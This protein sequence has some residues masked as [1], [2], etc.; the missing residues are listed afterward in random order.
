ME[1][2]RDFL[3]KDL[4][5]CIGQ[6]IDYYGCG[7]ENLEI[8]LIQEAKTGIFGIVGAR[9]A[10][11]R[12]RRAHV[13]EKVASMLNAT[14][15]MELGKGGRKP[16][17]R[18]ERQEAGPGG[19]GGGQ[20][21]TEQGKTSATRQ[22]RQGAPRAAGALSPDKGEGTDRPDRGER[23]EL[24]RAAREDRGRRQPGGEKSGARASADKAV[25]QAPKE[26]VNP[27]E[28][29]RKRGFAP[30]EAVSR[31]DVSAGKGEALVGGDASVEE[32]HGDDLENSSWPAR[33]LSELDEGVL[34][35]QT[36]EIVGRILE[37]IAGCPLQMTMELAQRSVRIHV[38][39]AGDAGLLIGRDGQTLAAVQYI[40]SRII[41]RAMKSVV[42]VQLDIG[43]YRARQEDKLCEMARSL[44]ERVLGTGK[45][46]STGPL[47]AYHRRLVH[48]SLQDNEAVQTRSIGDGPVKRVLISPRRSCQQ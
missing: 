42:R 30:S 19:S 11:I 31:P 46:M 7:R 12:A 26:S 24:P 2:F 3:G 6:A 33:P 20:C 10:K 38:E 5:D 27:G 29:E 1:N 22:R 45:P 47:S 25:R 35:S 14:D 8:E 17:D 15:P 41:S 43:N 39:W 48:L 44:A 21:A 34:R 32:S 28:Q 18:G 36:I 13:R 9:K 23:N 37:P 40:A 4:D 16:K